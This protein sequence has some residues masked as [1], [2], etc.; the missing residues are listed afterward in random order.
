MSLVIMFVG[1]M[2]SGKNYWGE[3][4]SRELDIPFFDGDSVITPEM[5]ERVKNFKGLTPELIDDYVYNHLGP[6]I[7]LLAEEDHLIVAQALYLEKHRAWLVRQLE[8]RGHR[9]RL[10]H[11]AT[12]FFQNMAQLWSRDNGLKW[13]LYW[14]LNKPFFQKLKTPHEVL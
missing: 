12:P 6:A 2:G 7:F 10:I 13:I 11:L 9:V 8:E 1:E 3:K 14:L 5:A 4:W